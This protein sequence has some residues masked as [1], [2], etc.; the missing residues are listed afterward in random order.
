MEWDY[1]AVEGR[2]TAE[3]R[4]GARGLGHL[5]RRGP[6]GGETV[7]AVGERVDRVI[8]RVQEVDGDVA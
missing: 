1:G 3:L 5:G 7:A 6:D 2:T 8:E 4:G